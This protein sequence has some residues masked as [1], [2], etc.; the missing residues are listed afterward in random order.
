M[1]AALARHDDI[2]GL[3]LLNI[4]RIFQGRNVDAD[5]RAFL[6]HL[7]GSEE[8][9][10]E[11]VEILLCD[12]PVHEDRADHAAPADESC[13]YHVTIL[14]FD[15]VVSALNRAGKRKSLSAAVS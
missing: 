9:R 13:S 2:G 4:V 3:Q 6:P 14:S 8:D 1:V 7:G 15:V 12:H 5:G 10:L 11:P